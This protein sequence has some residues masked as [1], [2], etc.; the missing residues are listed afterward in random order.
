MSLSYYHTEIPKKG[1]NTLIVASNRH[2]LK[3]AQ[4]PNILDPANADV[5]NVPAHVLHTINVKHYN[6][7]NVVAEHQALGVREDG[8]QG[9]QRCLLDRVLPVLGGAVSY[10]QQ[11]LANSRQHL[12]SSTWLD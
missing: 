4:K 3:S 1:T 7:P 10:L 6:R 5:Y 11:V 8:E 9:E 2:P 12:V